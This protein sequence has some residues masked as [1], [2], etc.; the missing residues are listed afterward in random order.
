[1]KTIRQLREERGWSQRELARRVGVSNVAI[2]YWE[3]GE[4]VPGANQLR[5]V[6]ATLSVSMDDIDFARPAIQETSND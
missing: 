2:W 1:M 4:R 3:N 6:A 5:A